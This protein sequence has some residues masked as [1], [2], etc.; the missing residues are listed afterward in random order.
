MAIGDWRVA[1]TMAGPSSGAAAEFADAIGNTQSAMKIANL[2]PSI[3]N[4]RL[5][6]Y[7]VRREVQDAEAYNLACRN[8][9]IRGNSWL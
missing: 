4:G 7:R 8:P 5:L 3:V 2:Q 6:A 9:G 1:L